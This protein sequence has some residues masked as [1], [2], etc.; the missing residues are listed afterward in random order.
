MEVQ[1]ELSYKGT[2]KFSLPLSFDIVGPAG[3]TQAE[4]AAYEDF[5]CSS[6]RQRPRSAVRR[7]S[8]WKTS[9][10]LPRL[11]GT[12]AIYSSVVKA[13]TMLTW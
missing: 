2:N 12:A 3:A 13:D 7:E 11:D 8:K 1:F 9:P 4:E 10:V 5:G 6:R